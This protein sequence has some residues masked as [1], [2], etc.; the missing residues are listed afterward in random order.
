M[1]GSVVLLLAA[2]KYRAFIGGIIAVMIFLEAYR[3]PKSDLFR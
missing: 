2:I 3:A 1:V